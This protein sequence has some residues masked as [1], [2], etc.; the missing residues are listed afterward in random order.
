[1]ELWQR[2]EKL[3][4][5]CQSLLEAARQTIAQVAGDPGEDETEF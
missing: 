5:H 3:A 2:G 1:M 4:N